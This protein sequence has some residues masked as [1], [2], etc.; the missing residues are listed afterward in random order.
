M[1]AGRKPTIWASSAVVAVAERRTGRVWGTGAGKAPNPMTSSTPSW[2]PRA[3]TS[4][5]NWCQRRS[6]SG[7]DSTS[8]LRPERLA[9]QRR[10]ISG[11]VKPMLTPFSIRM[12]GRRAR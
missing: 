1:V 2:R 9:P 6:G 8:R 5:V 7:P 11:Q 10:V 4:E 12:M 3:T